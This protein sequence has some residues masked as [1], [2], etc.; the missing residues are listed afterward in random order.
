MDDFLK[1]LSIQLRLQ[2]CLP[3]VL[4]GETGCGKTALVRFLADALGYELRVRDNHGGIRDGD[5]I[6]FLE[7]SIAVAEALHVG[8]KLLVFLDE[9]N[10]TNCMALFKSVLVDRRLGA[11]LVP[12]CVSLI[13]CCNPY[14]LRQN[15]ELE[16]VALV[17]T[18]HSKE[19][20]GI[21]DPMRHLVHRVHPVPESH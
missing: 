13:A 15:Q 10:A 6:T 5:I 20:G 9:I 8:K 7:A 11:R 18:H 16:E 12:Q 3:I 1:V 21:A 19:V 4:M 17:Y 2:L 14:R